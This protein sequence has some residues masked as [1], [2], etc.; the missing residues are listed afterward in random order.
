MKI[1]YNHQIFHQKYGGISRYFVELANRIAL[2]NY[3]R[4]TVKIISPLFK[5]DYLSNKNQR[6]LLSGL[7]IPDFKGSARVCSIF[8]SFLSPILSRHYKPDII[9][10]TYYNSVKHNNGYTKK[11]IT[12][13]DMIHERFPDHFP[14]ED[15]TTKLKKFAVE[16]A[17]HVICISKNTQKDLINFFNI[18]IKKTSVVYLGFSF[19]SKKIKNPVKKNKPYLLYVGSRNGYKNFAR[20]IKAYSTPKIKN[21]F[22]LVIFGGGS[23]DKE[24]D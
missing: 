22:D 7:K 1:L 17:D 13:Y 12:V 4:S 18:N 21:F 24:R 19:G 15:K 11:I 3:N 14:K 9:H 8:N 5:T 23:L 6:L 2:K 20:F 10:D 16:E